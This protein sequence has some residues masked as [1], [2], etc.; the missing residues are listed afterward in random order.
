MVNSQNIPKNIFPCDFAGI[1][2]LFGLN[3]SIKLL[4]LPEVAIYSIAGGL[5]TLIIIMWS[6]ALFRAFIILIEYKDEK[7]PLV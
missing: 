2:I 5:K 6:F 7:C 4:D 1:V 3:I